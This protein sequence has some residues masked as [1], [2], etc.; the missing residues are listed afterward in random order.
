[1]GCATEHAD[2]NKA[3]LEK[4]YSA[5]IRGLHFRTRFTTMSPDTKEL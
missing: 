5:T 3:K 2:A 1:M 4:A